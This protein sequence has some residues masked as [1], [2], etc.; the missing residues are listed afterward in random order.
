MKKIRKNVQKKAEGDENWY[1]KVVVR[2]RAAMKDERARQTSDEKQ[3]ENVAAKERMRNFRTNRTSAE[4]E[5]AKESAKNRMKKIRNE[6][7]EEM[8]EYEKIVMKQKMRLFRKQRSGKDHLLQN[9]KAKQGMQ[10][11]EEEGRLRGFSLRSAGKVEEIRD[12]EMYSN[13]GEEY[14]EFLKVKKPDV[15]QVLN[16]KNRVENE[17]KRKREELEKDGEWCYHGESGEYY[18]S[19][20]GEPDYGDNFEYEAPTAED[21]KQSR[22][23]EERLCEAFR[24]EKKQILREK[25]K[26]KEKER[27]DMMNTPVEPLP[28]RAL[29]AYEKLRE[30]NIKERED[31]MAESEFFENLKEYKT[32][33]GFIKKYESKKLRDKPTNL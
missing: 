25:R 33:I 32:E 3:Y 9:L 30:K 12:W 24:E 17:K 20:D 27:K 10:L 11:L 28:E 4:M 21:L 6:K 8:K 26:Q 1:E 2:E 5:E 31:A 15:V 16:E 13:K 29:C 14:S 19:G 7:T 23:Y 18:W 22:E